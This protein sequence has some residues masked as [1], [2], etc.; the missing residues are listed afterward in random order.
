MAQSIGSQVL[1]EPGKNRFEFI[2]LAHEFGEKVDWNFN[3]H[4]K[5]W[6]Y[7]LHYFEFLHAEAIPV[8]SAITALEDFTRQLPQIKEAVEPYPTSLRLLYWIRYFAHYNIQVPHWTGSMYA[9][10]YALL[11][12][13]ERHLLGNHYLENGFGLLFA[14][15]RYQDQRLYEAAKGILTRELAEQILPD[16]G[17][18]E[19][20]PMYHQIILY[21]LLDAINLVGQNSAVFEDELQ[22]FLE[23]KAALM[24]GWMQQMLPN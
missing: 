21:R 12:Q 4:G 13:S 14:A 24:L 23:K 3:E 18:F 7:N 1:W 11:D 2:G 17:H 20:S 19:R 10:A 22:P 9:Q 6:T 16:G 15:Y 5:L 8:D